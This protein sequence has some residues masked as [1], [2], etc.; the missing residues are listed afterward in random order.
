MATGEYYNEFIDIGDFTTLVLI[1]KMI[2]QYVTDT[3]NPK[4]TF[5]SPYEGQVEVVSMLDGSV[6]ETET[7]N[8]VKGDNDHNFNIKSAIIDGIEYVN[9][10]PDGQ[11]Y[12][13]H[14][15]TSELGSEDP[16]GTKASFIIE[17]RYNLITNKFDPINGTILT[18]LLVSDFVIDNNP[19]T[20]NLFM[21]DQIGVEINSIWRDPGYSAW[22]DA[23]R[24]IYNSSYD[25]NYNGITSG[26]PDIIINYYKISEDGTRTPVSNIDTSN[27][28]NFV[29]T[30]E[31]SEI[32]VYSVAGPSNY[33]YSKRLCGYR[34]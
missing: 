18:K 32:G 28:G 19:P 34:P 4:Y 30:Y 27:L 6:Y 11:Y 9:S 14:T 25:D 29:I 26:H 10:C 7:I 1:E 3:V 31:T 33:V 5:E 12:G 15:G 16:W 17:G 22:D 21:G 20:I 23:E 2:N 13:N 24:M 8:V